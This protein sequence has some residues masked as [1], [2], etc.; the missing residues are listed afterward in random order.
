[1]YLYGNSYRLAKQSPKGWGH[2]LQDQ[3]KV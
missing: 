3:R 1:V 2:R